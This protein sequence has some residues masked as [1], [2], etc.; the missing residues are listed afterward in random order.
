LS[1]IVRKTPLP[2]P[3][4]AELLERKSRFV[5]RALDELAPFVIERAAGS[6]V[7]DL[8]GNTFIDMTGGIGCLNVGHASPAVTAAVED[9]ARRF[10]HTDFTVIPY[11]P[12]VELAERLAGRAP[13]EGPHKV[14]FFNSGAEAVENAV[15]IAK[16]YTRRHALVA[17]EGGFHGRTLMAM[18]L[19]SKAKPY[20]AG[21]G[22]FAPDVYRA[23]YAYCYRCPLGA[24]HPSCGVACADEVEG[25]LHTQVAPSEVAAM[26]IEPV[27]GE[28]GFVVP[29]REFMERMAALCR[30]HGILFVA[31]EIQTGYGRTGHFFAVEEWGLAP[32]LITV[33]KSIAAG[34]PLSG[35]I[36]R[37][38]V[39]DAPGDGAIGGTFVGNPLACVAGLAVLDDLDGQDL[40]ARARHVGGRLLGRFRDMQERFPLIGDVRGLGAMVAMELVR[41]RATKEPAGR[42]TSEIIRRAV[43]GGA[44]FLKAGPY[45]NVIRVLASLTIPD[46]Q[47]D[48]ALDVLEGAVAAV[49]R[50]ARG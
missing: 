5:P 17:F 43:E 1:F 19:T 50:E 14:A 16:A 33:A 46:D 9:Q 47:L 31:D 7:T 4:S 13:G 36:G 22:P 23:P 32:D 41:D 2:G 29:P 15:K 45:G 34:L 38:E 48:E 24:S 40:V 20:K 28:G 42:E 27:Q 30:E 35:V 18:S 26:V 11:A 8:D 49:S 6:L 12:Y 21:F 3:R 25:L 44:I 39:M 37:A 10:L